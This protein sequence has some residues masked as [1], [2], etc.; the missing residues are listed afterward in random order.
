ME[1]LLQICDRFALTHLS[2]RSVNFRKL[3][4]RLFNT[5]NEII[6]INTLFYISNTLTSNS[7]L[8]LAKNQAKAKQHSETELLLFE[9]YL[10]S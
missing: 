7:R 6:K 9:N 3:Q 8:K 1:L 10:L 2:D 5:W 4:L